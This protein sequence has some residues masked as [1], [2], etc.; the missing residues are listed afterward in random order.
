MYDAAAAHSLKQTNTKHLNITTA[1][2]Y[3]K[4]VNQ[5]KVREVL[6]QSTQAGSPNV[7]C[8]AHLAH[9]GTICA[10]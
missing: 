4:K 3:A 2:F 1:N 5:K 6:I 9:F 10:I 7:Q 8:F